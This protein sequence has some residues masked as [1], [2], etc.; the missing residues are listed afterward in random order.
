MDV[1]FDLN[2]TVIKIGS[3]F[4]TRRNIRFVGR[5]DK[6]EQKIRKTD[7]DALKEN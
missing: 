4:S 3:A 5:V 2:D 1:S 7:S 6:M